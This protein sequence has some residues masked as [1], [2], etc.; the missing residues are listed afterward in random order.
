MAVDPIA[1]NPDLNDALRLGG[2]DFTEQEE[3]QN[4]PL[5]RVIGDNK[6][7]VSKAT[8]KLWSSRIDQSKSARADIEQCWSEAIR[9]YEND[10]TSHRNG[11]RAGA[12]NTRYVRA[13]GAAWSET[14]NVVFS[15][16]TL[17][18]PML[19]AKNPAI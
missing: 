1:S 5:Y 4:T 19:Y 18:L 10:Q 7:P 15:N 14:E 16:A 9:Y 11:G 12:G 8:G 13:V 6:I 17:M 2:D 3:A